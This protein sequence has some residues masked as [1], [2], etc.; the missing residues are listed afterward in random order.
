MVR[1]ASSQDTVMT[2]IEIVSTLADYVESGT[3]RVRCFVTKFL[4]SFLSKATA[5]SVEEMHDFIAQNCHHLTRWCAFC[6]HDL[7]PY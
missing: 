2:D 7:S 4:V 5:L 1:R 3:D 6:C